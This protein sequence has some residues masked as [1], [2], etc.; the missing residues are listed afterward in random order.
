MERMIMD[1]VFCSVTEKSYADIVA[2]GE[3]LGYKAVSQPTPITFPKCKGEVFVSF[4]YNWAL[5]RLEW[6]FAT[7][8]LAN[9]LGINIPVGLAD[10]EFFVYSEASKEDRLIAELKVLRELSL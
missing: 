1:R 7:R 3:V 6:T 5:K 8:E 9:S 10:G 2:K 4:H